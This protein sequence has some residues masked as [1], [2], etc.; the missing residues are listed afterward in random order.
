M[1]MALTMQPSLLQEHNTDQSLPRTLLAQ[2][3]QI[4]RL[5]IQKLLWVQPLCK[6]NKKTLH[7]LIQ[8]LCS[9][10][11]RSR[12]CNCPSLSGVVG[13]GEI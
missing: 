11:A 1:L 6:L 9:L 3:A 13:A 4:P 12:D 2:D 10:H 8:T 5:E 7:S